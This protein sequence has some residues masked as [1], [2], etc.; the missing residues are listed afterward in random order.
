MQ[1]WVSNEIILSIRQEFSFTKVA[2]VESIIYIVS[3]WIFNQCCSPK[4][5]HYHLFFR[6]EIYLLECLYFSECDIRMSLYNFLVEKGTTNEV[7][8]QLATGGDGGILQNSYRCV[9]REGKSCLMCMY[10]LTQS[11]FMFLVTF[12]SYSVLFYLQKFNFTFFF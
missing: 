2:P 1:T 7:P 11:V 9:Q 4:C 12:L 5:L 8:T 3:Y 6:K 10:A